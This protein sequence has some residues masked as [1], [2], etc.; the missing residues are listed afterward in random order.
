MPVRRCSL[1]VEQQ[2]LELV[3]RPMEP[4]LH[5]ADLAAADLGHLLVGE[6][7]NP[8]QDEHLA[9]RPAKAR[10]SPPERRNLDH[11]LLRGGNGAGLVEHGGGIG[12]RLHTPVA[13]EPAEAVTEDREQ[14]RP[15]VGAGGEL[16]LR[17]QTQHHRV[18]HEVVR[19][20]GIAGEAA[21]ENPQLRQQ[22]CQL[23][24]EDVHGPTSLSSR[25]DE[26]SFSPW[27]TMSKVG[28]SGGYVG[29]KLTGERELPV[30]SALSS[31]AILPACDSTCMHRW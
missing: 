30:A 23:R 10:K 27:H 18:L 24:A 9:V 20:V 14:P 13:Q 19:K 7:V 4:A 5:G 28:R 12:L 29:K 26:R 8:D 25:P 22:R 21:G 3:A 1:P 15:E 17:L 11:R 2:A 16:S 31:C 6:A